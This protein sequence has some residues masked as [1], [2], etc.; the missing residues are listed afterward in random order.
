MP[1]KH[2]SGR[3]TSSG[4]YVV[5]RANVFYRV[6]NSAEFDP[7]NPSTNSIHVNYGPGNQKRVTLLPSFSV[8]VFIQDRLQVTS[9]SGNGVVQGIYDVLPNDE[10]RNGRFKTRGGNNA[11]W[12]NGVQIVAGPNGPYKGVY[13]IFNSGAE[14]FNVYAFKNTNS[15]LIGTVTPNQSLDFVTNANMDVKV[16]AVVQ[17]NHIEGMYELLKEIQN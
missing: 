3:F 7:A 5:G 12:A 2:R 14:D 13:R 17:G 15:S 8:D 10:V 6:I 4:N 1:V 16:S 9:A 11:T